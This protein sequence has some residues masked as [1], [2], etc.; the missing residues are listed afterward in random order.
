MHPCMYNY[1]KRYT[2]TYTYRC[3]HASLQQCQASLRSNHQKKWNVFA[4]KRSPSFE[5]HGMMA[6]PSKREIRSQDTSK[7]PSMPLHL[8][9]SGFCVKHTR[10]T[11]R[12]K[13]HGK[14]TLFPFLAISISRAL[15]LWPLR[16]IQQLAFHSCLCQNHRYYAVRISRFAGW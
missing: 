13:P 15:P 1:T 2:C 3:M 6:M 5:R 4:S 16:A 7:I 14:L 9:L 8:P 11:L 10:R 12:G